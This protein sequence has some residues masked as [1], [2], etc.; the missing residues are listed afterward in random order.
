VN[1]L[2]PLVFLLNLDERFLPPTATTPSILVGEVKPCFALP[3]VVIGAF[4]YFFEEWLVE[5][6]T[7]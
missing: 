2:L 5:A 1:L 4:M 7:F 6:P 3:E